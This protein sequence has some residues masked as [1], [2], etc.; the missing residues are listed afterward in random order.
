MVIE[1]GLEGA[2]VIFRPPI[3]RHSKETTGLMR[4]TPYLACELVAVHHWKSDVNGGFWPNFE[5]YPQTGG[6]IRGFE[7][8]MALNLK[9]DL[10]ETPTYGRQRF[11]PR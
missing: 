4:L 9:H 8:F 3:P 6:T 11:T 7:D 1:A 5:G 2:T 10:F